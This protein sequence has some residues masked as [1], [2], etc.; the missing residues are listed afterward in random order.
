MGKG[1]GTQGSQSNSNLNPAVSQGL[2]ADATALTQ[3][4]E[5]Q[6]QEGQQ[7][8]NLTEPGLAKAENFYT[9]L[10]SGD[11]AAIMQVIAPG[12]QAVNQASQGAKKNILETPGGGG[13]KNLALE[14]VDVSRASDVGKMA[15]GAYTGSFNALGQL[16][17]Q[18]IG[19]SLAAT[20]QG[21]S[22]TATG[23]TSLLGLGGLNLN[24]AQLQM[25][26]KGQQLGIYGS[27]LNFAG[28]KLPSMGG[29]GG[30]GGGTG[31]GKGKGSGGG[32]GNGYGGSGG[33]QN[34][35]TPG[36]GSSG[37]GSGTGTYGSYAGGGAYGG[38]TPVYGTDSSNWQGTYASFS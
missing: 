4:A 16:A 37:S 29:G 35:S 20:G 14:N 23:S 5:Q 25:E 6:N 11:P 21:I 22:A 17:G 24:D 33:Y 2:L 38:G 15:G 7:L 10:S 18:G 13:E 19:E 36:Y 27:L 26:Q 34:Y 8:Y 3:I 31:S 1:K 32:G 28:S 30:G 12:A 9:A